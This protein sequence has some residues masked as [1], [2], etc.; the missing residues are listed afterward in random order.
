METFTIYGEWDPKAKLYSGVVP[1]VP[2]AHSQ[3]ASLDELQQNMQ[4]VIAL[5]LEDYEGEIENLPRLV[6]VQ[7]IEVAA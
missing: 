4:E 2:G 1:C 6:G 5:C 3:A 7:H